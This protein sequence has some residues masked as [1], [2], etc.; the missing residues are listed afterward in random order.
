MINSDNL[1]D[2]SIR[3]GRISAVGVSLPADMPVQELDVSGR[4]VIPG[5][6]DAHMHLDKAYALDNGMK[7]ADSLGA[8]I[9]EFFEWSERVT[10]E[11]VY[12]NACYA[13]EQALLQGTIALRTHVSITSGLDW[14]EMHLRLREEMAPWLTIQ[15]VVFPESEMIEKTSTK[16]LVSKAMELGADLIGGATVVAPDQ[17]RAVDIL[18]ELAGKHDCGL[19]LHVDESDD[20]S[21]NSLE[22][23]AERKIEL[24]F[25][26]SVTVGHC[27][28]LSAM[29]GNNASRVI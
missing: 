21:D 20:P 9:E 29:G 23:I 4:L 27:C 3:D 8:A 11:Q 18:F 24:G 16:Q 1:V 5:F 26:P 28:S 7:S 10:P 17:R 19:D 6:V 22:Y 25:K 13:A 15:L 12:V 14:L 2:I